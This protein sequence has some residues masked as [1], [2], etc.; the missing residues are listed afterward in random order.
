[1]SLNQSANPEPFG[2]PLG[3]INE[4]LKSTSLESKL[5][6]DGL[7]VFYQ[8]LTAKVIVEEP[9]VK[10]APDTNLSAITTIKTYLPEQFTDFLSKPEARVAMNNMATFASITEDDNGIFLGSRLTTYENEQGWD[11]YFP[12]LLFSIISTNEV[13]NHCL[14]IISGN[15]K[16]LKT[17]SEWTEADFDLTKSYLDKICVCTTGGPGLTAEFGIDP[18]ATTAIKGDQTAL[19]RMLANEPH[20]SLGGGLFCIL[21][22]PFGYERQQLF[23]VI[24]NLNKSEMLPHD[25]PPHFGAWTIGNRKNNPAYITFLPNVLHDQAK[26]IQVNM[27][28]WA[29]QRV[30]TAYAT[31][32]S[33]GYL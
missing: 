9:P 6:E 5:I 15:D 30:Q 7:E 17:A 2:V 27:S 1:M 3:K 24:N 25:L 31:L 26:N 10:E 20:I 33:H 13:F 16:P 11:I 23:E 18:R 28:M 32:L 21:E 8:N 12:L 4:L 29:Y 14:K 19:W 22:M